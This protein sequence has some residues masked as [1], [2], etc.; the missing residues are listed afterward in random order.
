MRQIVGLLH[1][2]IVVGSFRHFERDL[3]QDIEM[4][5]AH[6]AMAASAGIRAPHGQEPKPSVIWLLSAGSCEFF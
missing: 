3:L 2:M 1:F 4:D 5:H 6:N